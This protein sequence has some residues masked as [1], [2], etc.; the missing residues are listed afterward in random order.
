ME[1]EFENILACLSGLDEFESWK[2][3]GQKYRDTLPLM[4]LNM[5]PPLILIFSAAVFL[6]FQSFYILIYI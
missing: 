5:W 3:G 6:F 2:N 4:F 1:T